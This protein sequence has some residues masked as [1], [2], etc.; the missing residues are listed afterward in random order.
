MLRRICVAHSTG[1]LVASLW[2]NRHPDAFDALIL[3]SPWLEMQGSYLVRYAAA[4]VLEPLARL[5]PGPSCTCRKW[6]TTG[7]RISRRPTATGTCTRSGA[8]R[9]PSR[10]RA[11]W[12]TAV[13]AG[14]ARGGRGLDIKVPVLVLAS[15]TSHLGTGFDESM[16]H[17]EAV[18]DV[19]RGARAFPAAWARRSPMRWLTAPCTTCSPRCPARAR[20]PTR[21]STAGAPATCRAPGP[22]AWPR[23]SLPKARAPPPVA[24]LSTAPP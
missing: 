2:V 19:Q 8:R 3:N 13:M 24:G 20:R 14:H 18:L 16:L 4:G 1:G 11:G 12:I 9:F 5:R 23:A 15:K 6:T 7:A 22:G 17:H 21:R 10:S